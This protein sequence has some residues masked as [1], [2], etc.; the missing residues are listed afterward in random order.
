MM[1]A[2]DFIPKQTKEPV[3][4]KSPFGHPYYPSYPGPGLGM[5]ARSKKEWQ[6]IEI[7]KSIREK[8]EWWVKYKDEVITAKWRKELE[9]QVEGITQDV[10]DYAFA[11]LA[12]FETLKTQTGDRFQAACHESIYVSVDGVMVVDEALKR[13]FKTEAFRLLEEGVSESQKDWH[14]HTNN[15]VLDLVHPSLYPLQYG[16]TPVVQ[17]DGSTAPVAFDATAIRSVKPLVETFGLSERFQW[18]PSIFSLGAD[19][20]VTIGSYI[21]NLHPEK[22]QTLYQPLADIFSRCLPGLKA[23]LSLALSPEYLRDPVSTNEEEIYEKAFIEEAMRLRDPSD[24]EDEQ[25]DLYE[26]LWDTRADHMKTRV[27]EYQGA[28]KIKPFDLA[29]FDHLKVI[30]KLANIHLTPESPEYAGGSWHVEGT[31]NEDII[32][33]V[34]YYYD[35]ENITESRLSFRAALNEPEYEQGEDVFVREIFGLEDEQ[36]LNHAMGSVEAKE[37]RITIFPNVF[38]HHVDAFELA[39]RTKPGHR[40]IVCFFIVDP[41]NERVIA[42]DRVP[43]QQHEPWV[44]S[45][46]DNTY[47]S[48]FPAELFGRIAESVEWPMTM[49]KAKAV[50]EELMAERSANNDPQDDENPFVREFSLCEH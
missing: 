46:R 28:Q 26:E 43:P 14:P 27:V 40:K 12:F 24:D 13:V 29:D 20:A 23:C 39:D 44:E 5:L 35:C 16:L 7:S 2:F 41:Y 49:A 8:A 15:Q 17:P 9:E 34:L 33:T 3:T 11:E 36:Q 31:I 45:L 22:H 30:T 21:N 25:W 19:G 37:D 47:L 50:R 18:L 32:A 38:Q 10:I 42:T 48:Q 6:I 1:E 4:Y